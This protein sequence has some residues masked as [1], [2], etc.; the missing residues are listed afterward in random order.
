M[1]WEALSD[2]EKERYDYERDLLRWMERLQ[3]DLRKRIEANT[4][5]LAATQKPAFLAEDKTAMES[6][7]K[8]I[9]ALLA[10]AAELG[11]QGEVDAAEAATM[12]ADG[13]RIRKKELERQADARSGNASRGLVQSVCPVS[14]LII[15]DEES[16]LRDHHTGRNYNAWKKLHAMYTALDEKL[17]KRRGGGGGGGGGRGDYR[18]HRDR[19]GDRGRPRRRSRSYERRH[20]SR[21]R[22]ASRGRSRSGERSRRRRD[23]SPKARRDNGHGD[24]RAPREARLERAPSPEEGEV[25]IA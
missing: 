24:G 17:S 4:V 9:A 5:R 21:S 10:K 15:N 20:R 3:N 14:G 22:S 8:E 6:I 13:L 1:E 16:R 23:Y 12:E 19:D 18:R 11:E 7:D 2:R 25:G